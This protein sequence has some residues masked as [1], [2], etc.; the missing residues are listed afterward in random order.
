MSPTAYWPLGDATGPAA[1]EATHNTGSLAGVYGGTFSLGIPTFEVGGST[2]LFVNTGGFVRCPTP[3]NGAGTYTLGCYASISSFQQAADQVLPSIGDLSFTRGMHTYQ[4]ANYGRFLT[5]CPGK[6]T[7]SSGTGT[8]C[9]SNLATNIWNWYEL[10]FDNVG[11][12]VGT[13][14][15]GG[16]P[17][18]NTVP[19]P[20]NWPTAADYVFCQPNFMAVM[21]HLVIWNRLLTTTERA[22]L[23]GHLPTWQYGPPMNYVPLSGSS[24]ASLSPTDPVVVDINADLSNIYNAVHHVYTNPP[25]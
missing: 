6:G 10:V 4:L 25:S 17:Y 22:V 1:S 5:N 20:P 19:W 24:S 8:G 11:L 3:L 16:A 9:G 2:G 13:I 15:S 18:F 12:R 7:N 14:V 21:A 23:Y